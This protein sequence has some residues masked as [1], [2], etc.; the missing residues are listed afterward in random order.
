ME[1]LI[2]VLPAL[3]YFTLLGLVMNYSRKKESI[4]SIKFQPKVAV[5]VAFRDE[6]HNLEKLIKAILAQD[7]QNFD[8]YLVN[9]HS[10]DEYQ[11]VISSFDDERIHVLHLPNELTGKKRA[12]Q[13]GVE[14]SNSELILTTDA[15]CW[16]GKDWVITMVN[17][18]ESKGKDWQAGP[19]FIESNKT[20]LQDFQQLESTYLVA[21]SGFLI[22][23]KTPSTCN[24]A[25]IL[26]RRAVFENVNA[27]EGLHQ[28]PSG[29]D[30]LLMQKIY[31]AGYL[32]NACKNPKAIVKTNAQETK[33][34]F[35]AQRIRWASKLK[36]NL[37]NYNLYLSA[38]VFGFHAS[39][40]MLLFI[41]FKLGLSLLFVRFLAEYLLAFVLYKKNSETLKVIHFTISF[42]VYPLYVIF[43]SVASQLKS[44]IW[45]GRKY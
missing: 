27:F 44:Y 12:I 1:T 43:M 24:G 30:E 22:N 7:Y 34:S 40:I 2:L 18:L 8:L 35:L 39:I 42:F 33:E 25:N 6:A 37:L 21:I 45:K 23:K 10:K 28:T 20:L 31:I 19:I 15:D 41:D 14:N 4:E 32:L 16:M 17:E 11:K 5:I 26:M 36:Y 3:V 13:F 38:L 9:D 29:D